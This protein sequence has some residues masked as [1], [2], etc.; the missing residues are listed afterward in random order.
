MGQP[1]LRCKA[2][3][4]SGNKAEDAFIGALTNKGRGLLPEEH[5]QVLI[6]ILRNLY[7]VLGQHS[8]DWARGENVP[9]WN[10]N[11]Y[12]LSQQYAR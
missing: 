12:G 3:W 4:Q 5:A 11:S 7:F 10:R 2:L 6:A 1:G 9:E 8:P